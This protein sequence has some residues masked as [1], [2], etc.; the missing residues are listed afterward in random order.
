[1]LIRGLVLNAIFFQKGQGEFRFSPFALSGLSRPP[2]KRL[3]SEFLQEIPVR[4]T[5]YL[6]VFVEG[7]SF[8]MQPGA[9]FPTGAEPR[10]GSFQGGNGGGKVAN[11]RFASFAF[12]KTA[13]G[14]NR[15]FE[16]QRR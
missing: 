7:Q 16:A 13:D 14:S 12:G 15:R 1:M 3:F 4:G 10:E 5:N 2:L 6:F 9:V 11:H 8:P